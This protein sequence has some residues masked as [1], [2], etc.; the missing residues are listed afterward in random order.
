MA[1]KETQRAMFSKL[2]EI[3]EV[4][5][6]SDRSPEKKSNNDRPTRPKGKRSNPNFSQVGVYLRKDTVMQIRQR[7]LQEDD[8]DLSD[9]IEELLVDFLNTD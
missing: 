2:G 6:I 8:R 1:K 9:L 5:Q 4:D 7:L 3:A